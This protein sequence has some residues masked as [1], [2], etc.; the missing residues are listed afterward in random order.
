M[1][2]KINHPLHY[3]PGDFET[4]KVA[5]AWGLHKNAYL[6]NVLKY[7]SRAGKKEGETRLTDLQK[8]Q[9]YLNR[10]IEIELEAQKER[11]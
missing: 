4:Y 11:E 9:W 5:E 7:L 10:E 2:D 6:F 1:S 8:M 3:S